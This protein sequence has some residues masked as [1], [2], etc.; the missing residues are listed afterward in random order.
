MIPRLAPGL[1]AVPWLLFAWSRADDVDKLQG[2]L[3]AGEAPSQ[4]QIR[5]ATRRFDPAGKLLSASTNAATFS[6]TPFLLVSRRSQT[7]DVVTLFTSNAAWE[8]FDALGL[9]N[10]YPTTPAG[11]QKHGQ[12]LLVALSAARFQAWT[13]PAAFARMPIERME[14]GPDRSDAILGLPGRK[15]AL[16]RC[17]GSLSKLLGIY[18]CKTAPDP[19]KISERSPEVLEAYLFGNHRP[20]AGLPYPLP[21]RLTGFEGGRQVY[22]A[23]ILSFSLEALSVDQI[24]ASEVAAYEKKYVVKER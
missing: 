9:L 16:L 18:T 4:Y 13:Y 3:N 20:V 19:S 21:W 1:L 5:F 22:E 2:L 12:G 24:L 10:R 14:R 8:R 11:L 23:E 6:R 15:L 7:P 17:D